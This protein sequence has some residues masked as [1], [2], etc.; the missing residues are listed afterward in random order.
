MST[1]KRRIAQLFESTRSPLR[2]GVKFASQTAQAC[3]K[4]FR[5][6]PKATRSTSPLG[7][8]SVSSGHLRTPISTGSN[9]LPYGMPTG[10]GI[11][12]SQNV[13]GSTYNAHWIIR[14]TTDAATNGGLITTVWSTDNK[15]VNHMNGWAH[16]SYW[17]HA[18]EDYK[19][20]EGL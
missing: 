1:T 12:G 9:A 19:M 11:P 10:S 18:P 16:D 4:G 14:Y 15:G 5:T 13:T 8:G 20:P 2:R 7:G 3:R 17:P 6:A